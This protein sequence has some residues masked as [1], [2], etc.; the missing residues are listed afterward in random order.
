MKRFLTLLLVATMV[1]GLFTACVPGTQGNNQGSGNSSTGSNGSVN[2]T[3]PLETNVTLTMFRN[4]NSNVTA[5]FDSFG[6]TPVAQYLSKATGINVEYMDTYADY[7]AF[8]NDML[9]T[10]NYTDLISF[11]PVTYEGGAVDVLEDGLG[12]E[13]ND[14]IDKYMPNFKAY[15][16]ANP[17]VDKAIKTDDGIYYYIPYVNSNTGAYSY[18]AY[19][20]EDMLKA[21]G[22]TEPTT[23]DEWYDLLVKVKNTYNIIPVSCDFTGLIQYGMMAMAYGVGSNSTSNHFAVD[24]DGQVFYQRSSEEWKAF[25]KEMNKWYEEGLIDTDVAAIKSADVN[26]KMIRGNVFLSMGWLTGAMQ[27]VQVGGVEYGIEGF[28]LKAVGTPALTAGQQ[29]EYSYATTLVSGVGT[30]ISANCQNVEIAAR[31]LDY[32]FSEEGHLAANYGEP[33][34]GY[35]MVDGIPTF[36]DNVVKGDLLPEGY[37]QSQSA[38]RYSAAT[39][40]QMAMVKDE[41][42]Y[43]QL[44]DEECCAEAIYIWMNSA[45]GGGHMHELPNLTYDEDETE[46]I[47]KAV[48][49][50]KSASGEWASQFIRGLKDVDEDWDDYIKEIE[51]MGLKEALTI[52]NDAMER[53]AD[54]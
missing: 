45:V 10:G 16:A 53:Y 37:N 32:L 39:T 50:L 44:M 38:A 33:G 8:W 43:E 2:V 48:A 47:A 5:H 12:I 26:A 7:D 36:H 51:K 4:Q 11:N 21:M 46:A 28:Q 24:S 40:G 19:Y 23:M 30:T 41:Y 29:I 27:N 20:R 13:L 18:G 34:V 31:F 22:E 54:R 3:Y 25:L 14:I 52:M 49:N 9:S 1:I 35:D 42:Y 15:L 17:D 6:D